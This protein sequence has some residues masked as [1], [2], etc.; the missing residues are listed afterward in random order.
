MEYI[1]QKWGVSQYVRLAFVCRICHKEQ[2]VGLGTWYLVPRQTP[3]WY[4][5]GQIQSERFEIGKK[6][7]TIFISSNAEK[8]FMTINVGDSREPIRAQVY[9]K[10]KSILISPDLTH[11]GFKLF[12]VVCCIIVYRPLI[13]LCEKACLFA[14]YTS[15]GRH[16]HNSSKGR[17]AH[18][19]FPHPFFTPSSS[20][21]PTQVTGATTTTVTTTTDLTRARSATRSSNRRQF[22]LNTLRMFTTSQMGEMCRIRASCVGPTSIGIHYLILIL[23]Q[24]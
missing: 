18:I 7:K 6:F 13:D 16:A 15:K 17:H 14:S 10:K 8:Y 21:P 20:R 3:S 22:S 2:Q 23:I 24:R 1:I 12:E 5:V 19:P 4:Q 11:Q 9:I